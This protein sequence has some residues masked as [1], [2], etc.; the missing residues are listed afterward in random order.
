[1]LD[2][3]HSAEEGQLSIRESPAGRDK[4]R[5]RTATENMGLFFVGEGLAGQ[6]A[7][8]QENPFSV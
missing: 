1:L 4:Q 5:V 6:F 8:A 7:T 2:W 3:K